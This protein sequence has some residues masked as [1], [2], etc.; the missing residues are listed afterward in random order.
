MTYAI[1]SVV[2]NDVTLHKDKVQG[3]P[4]K[5]YVLGLLKIPN[6]SFGYNVEGINKGVKSWFSKIIILLIMVN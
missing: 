1:N 2:D 4:L 6:W 3:T 5:N